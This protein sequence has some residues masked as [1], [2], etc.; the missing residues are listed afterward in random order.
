MEYRTLG[1]TGVQVSPLCL[2]TMNFGVRT[3]EDEAIKMID[4]AID[5]GI[6]F[7]DTANLYGDAGE[8]IGRSEQIIGRALSGNGKRSQIV[9]ATKVFF[10]TNPAD[11]NGGGLSRRH[12]ISECETSL[13]R[14]CTDHIDLY[15]LHCPMPEI[16]IDE[17]LRA[18]DDLIH[19]GKVIYIGTSNFSAWQLVEA[20]WI[21]D[22]H[23]LNRFVTDQPFYNM[24]YR[25]IERDLVPM[26]QR[27]G[28]AILPYSV[29]N[30]GI[31]TGK[32]RQGR[33]HPEGS[34]LTFK[35]WAVY[36][37]DLNEGVY[38]MLDLLAGMAT[39]KGCTIS[40]LSLAWALAQP[41]IT[42]LI[43]GPRNQEQLKDNLEALNVRLT[44][45]DLERID[46]IAK[47][48]GQLIS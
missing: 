1:R 48:G 7:I 32:Y 43:L 16:P 25:R 4:Q 40:Q 34:R 31:L 18:L 13:R 36:W 24:L 39:E 9:L 47:P 3:S 12:I 6:N 33:A 11:P 37:D 14:L 26:A 17:T 22:K 5:A 27:Y 35:P 28:I 21:S 41:G 45:A 44:S 30:G 42:S 29:L 20:L 38:A 2:G 23:N 10:N 46:A 19:A 15:Q 8:G